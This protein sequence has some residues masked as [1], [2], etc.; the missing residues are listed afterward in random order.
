MSFAIYNKGIFEEKKFM[1]RNWR[2]ERFSVQELN[3]NKY[4][5]CPYCVFP[6]TKIDWFI[7][8]EKVNAKL[9]RPLYLFRIF[10][11]EYI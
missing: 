5:A 4:G 11:F 9:N 7:K 6:R 2:F 10:F 1:I 3:N 8:D